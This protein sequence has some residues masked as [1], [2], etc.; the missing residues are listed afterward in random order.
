M[1]YVS[2]NNQGLCP[3]KPLERQE[4]TLFFILL[5]AQAKKKITSFFI[6]QKTI[7]GEANHFYSSV[8]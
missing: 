4:L 1:D 8:K 7:I 2:N 3:H 6:F 5:R